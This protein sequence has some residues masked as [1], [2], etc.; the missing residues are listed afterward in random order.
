[1]RLSI[2]V[3]LRI[4]GE[5]RLFAPKSAEITTVDS[6]VV[7]QRT[8]LVLIRCIRIFYFNPN[9]SCLKIFNFFSMIFV[10]D[11]EWGYFIFYNE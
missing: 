2:T 3:M 11:Q 9:A 6:A 5:L 8:V 1:M 10:Q 4:I 7:I